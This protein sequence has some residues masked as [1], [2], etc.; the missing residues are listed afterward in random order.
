M[1]RKRIDYD[2]PNFGE[3]QSLNSE[4]SKLGVAVTSHGVTLAIPQSAEERLSVGST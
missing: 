3:L 2:R 1:E 4:S